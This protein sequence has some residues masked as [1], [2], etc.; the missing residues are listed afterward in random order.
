MNVASF[1]K[2]VESWARG[3]PDVVGVALV[4]SRARDTSRPD[5]DVDLVILS[6]SPA[7]LLSGDWPA[8][9]GEVVASAIEDYGELRSRRVTY[10][11]GLEVEFGVAAPGWARLP[12]DPGTGG[13]LAGGVRVLHDPQGLFRVAQDAATVPEARAAYVGG[14]QRDRR[15]GSGA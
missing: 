4:G 2:A 5:S 10:R 1:L 8:S 11:S 14:A 3:R 9:F 6:A 12:L 15:Q 7:E 13:V